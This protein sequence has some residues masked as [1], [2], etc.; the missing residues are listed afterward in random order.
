M[1]GWREA[2]IEKARSKVGFDRGVIGIWYGSA[3]KELR[4]NCG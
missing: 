2:A 3:I 4:V 1:T